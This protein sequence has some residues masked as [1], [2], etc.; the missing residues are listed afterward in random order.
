M[1]TSE[2]TRPSCPSSPSTELGFPSSVCSFSSFSWF[3][4]EQA[5]ESSCWRMVGQNSWNSFLPIHDW[6][7]KLWAAKRAPELKH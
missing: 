3:S 6:L 4:E 7:L 1:K 5:R 2:G